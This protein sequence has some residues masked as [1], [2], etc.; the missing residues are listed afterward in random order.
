MS[1]WQFLRKSFIPTKRTSAACFV[2]YMWQDTVGKTVG[3]NWKTILKGAI[4]LGAYQKFK[5]SPAMF[6]TL[7]SWTGR[8]GGV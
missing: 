1:H 5:Q 8:T 4:A 2:I 7:V 6:R 3:G